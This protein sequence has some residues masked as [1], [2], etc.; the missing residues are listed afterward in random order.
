MGVDTESLGNLESL[1]WAASQNA[2][3]QKAYEQWFQGLKALIE[4]ATVELWSRE[5]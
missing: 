3:Y 2:E 4:V 1:F 5:A